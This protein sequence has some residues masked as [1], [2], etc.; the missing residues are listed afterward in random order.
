MWLWTSHPSRTTPDLPGVHSRAWPGAIDWLKSN[1]GDRTWTLCVSASALANR[2]ACPRA[3]ACTRGTNCK[4]LWSI[5][6][7]S[8]GPAVA[9]VAATR[10]SSGSSHT[11]AGLTSGEQT[12]GISTRPLT[13]APRAVAATRTTSQAVVRIRRMRLLAASQVR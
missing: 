1:P 9:A 5:S 4:P 12:S 2:M 7:T 8:A 3:I 10:P 13:S 6:A 11:T